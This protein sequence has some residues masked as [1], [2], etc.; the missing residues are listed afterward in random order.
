M[1]QSILIVI[2]ILTIAL[3]IALASKKSGV[4]PNPR[5]IAD[6]AALFQI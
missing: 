6:V 3:G 2:A 1:L 5:S 4:V